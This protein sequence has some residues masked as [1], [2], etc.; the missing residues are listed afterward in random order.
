[1]VNKFKKYQDT[2]QEARAKLIVDYLK[3]LGKSIK[4]RN[5]TNLADLVA[6]YLAE[7]QQ[8]PCVRSTLLRN[9]RYKKLLLN[10]IAAGGNSG[11]GSLNI[12]ESEI[13]DPK[14][15]AIIKTLQID[16]ATLRRESVR[17]KAYIESIENVDVQKEALENSPALHSVTA[18]DAGGVEFALVCK[19]F[20]RVIH[21]F[22]Q[23][24][25]IKYDENTLIDLSVV[26]NG[27]IVGSDELAPFITWLRRH[28]QIAASFDV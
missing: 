2:T 12:K 3:A 23:I 4:I 28:P 15:K 22:K 26:R 17:L 19:A 10:H 16:N 21:H 6:S 24:I 27:T 20:L 14:A 7:Q 25:S 5:V 18:D 13:R 11:R 1:M 8:K 9:Q